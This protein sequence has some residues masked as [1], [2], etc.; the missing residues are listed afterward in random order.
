MDVNKLINLLD[1]LLNYERKNQLSKIEYDKIKDD[2]M[3]IKTIVNRDFVSIE[4]DILNIQKILEK[5]PLGNKKPGDILKMIYEDIDIDEPD[6]K[7]ASA[8][9]NYLISFKE[10]SLNLLIE[11]MRKMRG[12]LSTYVFSTL[13]IIDAALN[14]AQKIFNKYPIMTV[15]L[16]NESQKLKASILTSIQLMVPSVQE[17]LRQKSLVEFTKP[18]INLEEYEKE[19]LKKNKYGK[20][21]EKIIIENSDKIVGGKKSRSI[22]KKSKNVI[23]KK[24]KKTQTKKKPVIKTETVIHKKYNVMV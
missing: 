20:S 2:I 18:F 1:G 13:N 11:R 4:Q 10:N 5:K 17:Y 9:L 12:L 8:T 6:A 19:F 16:E 22:K 14:E 3:E 21:N 24:K 7:K 23:T 15:N